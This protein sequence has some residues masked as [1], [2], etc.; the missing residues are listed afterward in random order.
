MAA[1]MVNGYIFMIAFITVHT[2]QKASSIQLVEFLTHRLILV[3]EML[4]RMKGMQGT[5]LFLCFQLF[6]VTVIRIP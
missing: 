6:W 3:A 1:W 2:V 5:F 4:L